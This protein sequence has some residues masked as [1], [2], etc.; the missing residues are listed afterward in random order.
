M[1]STADPTPAKVVHSISQPLS[2]IGN[3]LRASI[4]L[5]ETGEPQHKEQ[6]VEALRQAEA[7]TREATE[8]VISLRDKLRLEKAEQGH[9]TEG[10]GN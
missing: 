6:A 2:A 8:M 3:Y 5:L 7:C 10:A 9:G 1:S 4:R